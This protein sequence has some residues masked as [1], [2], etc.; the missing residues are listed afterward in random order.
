MTNR[1][2]IQFPTK[3][4][5]WWLPHLITWLV[6][7][8]LLL[9]TYQFFFALPY[10]GFDINPTSGE[11]IEVFMPTS[12]IQPGDQILAFNSVTWTDFK[13]DLNRPFVE[14][15][16]VGHKISLV[17]ER[18]QTPLFFL[19]SL[20]GQTAGELRHRLISQW[21][22]A[23][24]FWII[25]AITVLFVRPRNERWW[26]FIAFN[27]LTAIWL[28][29][30]ML[31]RWHYGSSAL[32]L[33]A[34]LWLSL[35]VYWHLHWVFPRPSGR[36]PRWVLIVGYTAGI[37][38]ASLAWLQL[39]PASSYIVAFMLAAGGSFVLLLTHYI[40]R[41]ES[42]HVLRFV[43][44][45][46]GTVSGLMA[47]LGIVNWAG[48]ATPV[49]AAALLA[50]PI[51]PIAYL[52]IIYH[53]Q[54]GGFE[55]RANQVI[56]LYF[57]ILL[58]SVIVL[59]LL[60][61]T[62]QFIPISDTSVWLALVIAT[63]SGLLTAV[64]FS[65]FQ[66]WIE[67]Y[68]LHIPL[69]PSKLLESYAAQIISNL[70]RES[71]AH[72]VQK[73]ILPTLLIRQSALARLD[74]ENPVDVIYTQGVTPYQVPQR[75]D[76]PPLLEQA[77]QYRPPL[78]NMSGPYSWIRLVLPLKVGK[79]IIG[80]WYFGKRDP[81]DV[82]SRSEIPTFR[83]LANQTA[84]ALNNIVQTENLHMMY[85]ANI[86]QQ[87]EER[88]CLALLLHD[89]ILND[90]AVLGMYIDEQSIAPQLQEAYDRL[91]TRLRQ[92]IRNL[93]PS[94]LEYGLWF[95][96]EQTVEYFLERDNAAI[97]LDICKSQVRYPKQVEQHIFWI[98]HQALE[99]A[100]EHSKADLI[101][102]E[103]TLLPDKVCLSVLDQ[104]QGFAP[105][106]AQLDL[107]KLLANKHFGL[108]GMYE[109][110]SLLGACLKITSRPEGGTQVTINWTPEGVGHFSGM[111]STTTAPERG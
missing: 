22:L 50:L 75:K 43:L 61:L 52:Y 95:A 31:S 13:D 18:D 69:T 84:I 65:T 99:N 105:E 15:K 73:D 44:V 100:L 103:G 70:D 55:V 6:F 20:P 51:L 1:R 33:R 108:I 53:H 78:E 16:P 35:P 86:N 62:H 34:T 38:M 82:Y 66:R 81:D 72:F 102:I 37:V 26:V 80:V 3:T 42:R 107:K 39:L 2:F 90:I 7:A 96:L 106:I 19:W 47:S 49:S 89:E 74:G 45:A 11:I 32:I 48:I 4:Y 83:A 85:Q 25:G 58:N 24:V 76:T 28:T 36:L 88:A 17:I 30:G 93:R 21:W 79:E 109:R 59:F 46:A 54:L 9:Q 92:T 14:D 64:G 94:I 8:L 68:L 27:F 10:F 101:Y 91:T 57:F 110:A 87:D 41:P 63:C 71:L 111:L 60:A 56:V 77:Y 104:G 97:Q 23:Y 5:L 40:Y 12:Q 67:R 29:A 98:I